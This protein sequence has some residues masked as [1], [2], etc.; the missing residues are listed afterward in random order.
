VNDVA[1]ALAEARLVGYEH[2]RLGAVRQ[3][4]SPLRL[5]GP[6]PPVRPGPARGEH[7]EDVLAEV[8]GYGPE[9]VRALAESGVFGVE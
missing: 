3:V 5:S 1:A 9:R 8:C 6:E 2:P 4:A 7:T